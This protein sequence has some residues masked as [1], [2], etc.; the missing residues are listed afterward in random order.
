ME[1]Q[2]PSATRNPAQ[3][4]SA[5]QATARIAIPAGPLV[6]AMQAY[7]AATGIKVQL[8]LPQLDSGATDSLQTTGIDGIYTHEEALRLLLTGTGLTFHFNS[9]TGASIGITNTETVEVT[10]EVPTSVAMQ[11]FTEPLLD[12]PQTIVS[13]PTFLVQD[14]GVTTLRDTLRNVPGISLAAGESGAQGDNLTIRGFT[15]RNDIFLDG[16]RDF[17]SYYR[18]SFDYEQVD[19]LEGPAGVQFGRGSTGGVINQESKIPTTQTIVHVDTQFGTNLERRITGDLNEPIPDFAGGSAVRLNFMGVEANVAERDKAEIRR[20]GIAP[21]IAFGLDSKTRASINY[22]HLNESDTPDYG[23]PWFFNRLAPGVDRRSYFGFGTSVNGH[24]NY[25]HTNDDIVTAKVDHDFAHET[26]LHTIARF[27]NYPR[28]VQITEPQ[29]LLERFGKRT[30]WRL[31]DGAADVRDQHRPD[32]RVH[33]TVRSGV[34]PRQ[35]QSDSDQERRKRP[36]GPDGGNDSLQD[37]WPA[38]RA[39]RRD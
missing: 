25:L 15:A 35:S 10:A 34:D 8:N 1:A 24:Q 26:N 12:T 9:Q 39:R 17:G 21:S 3:N 33:S 7:E 14:E 37:L 13:I 32:L 6:T 30:G 22:V 31:C 2:Q 18:D 38:Q 28:N 27:A 20:Y 5:S 19:V 16:I 4:S 29:N 23:L 11:K 36:V